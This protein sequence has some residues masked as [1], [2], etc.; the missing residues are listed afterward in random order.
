VFVLR[1]TKTEAVLFI[2]RIMKPIDKK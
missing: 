2:G 1:D